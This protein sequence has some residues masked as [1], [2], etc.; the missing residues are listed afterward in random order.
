MAG[1]K[2][3]IIH[4]LS[5][6]DIRKKSMSN[7]MIVRSVNKINCFVAERKQINNSDL[8]TPLVIKWSAPKT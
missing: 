3:K 8:K 1:E 5:P 4:Y 7:K 2:N 6:T